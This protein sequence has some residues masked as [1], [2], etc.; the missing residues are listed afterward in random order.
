LQ[1]AAV[2]GRTFY[3]RVLQSIYE[4]SDL[5]DLS[6]RELLHVEMIFEVARL[7]ELEYIFRHSLTRETAYRTILRQQRREYHLKVGEALEELF[8]DQIERYAPTLAYHFEQAGD[9]RRAFKYHLQAGESA[10]RLYAIPQAL[11]RFYHARDILRGRDCQTDVAAPETIAHLYRRLGRALE[12]DS[13]FANALANYQ[14]LENL[15]RE[16]ELEQEL[17]DALISQALL[18]CT[19]TAMFDQ[20]S[21]EALLELSMTLAQELGDQPSQAKILWLELNLRRLVGDHVGAINAGERSLEIVRKLDLKEQL[22]YTL[23]DLG[24]AYS[25]VGMNTQASES[26]LEAHDLWRE[27]KNKPMLADNIA[28]MIFIHYV[29]GDYE[30]AIAASEEAYQ[31]SSSIHNLWGQSFSL[32]EV[33]LVYRDRG[34]YA[35]AL[36]IM[37][38]SIDLGENG[39][40]P[41]PRKY[42]SPQIGLV[43]GDLGLCD[44]GVEISKRTIN[45]IGTPL[46]ELKQLAA[47]AIIH[48]HLQCGEVHRGEKIAESWELPDDIFAYLGFSV[49]FVAIYVR[50]LLASGDL[51]GAM[52]LS[53]KLVDILI[54]SGY[55]GFLPEV[56]YYKG[57]VHLEL[58]DED[59]AYRVLLDAMER[60]E[61]IGHRRM[62]WQI[63]AAL[64]GLSLPEEAARLRTQALDILTF[65]T[66]HTPEGELRRSFLAQP[67]V[68]S[69]IEDTE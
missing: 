42:V 10:M 4:S 64:A 43:Y 5:L 1:L 60:A 2:I 11:E 49:L 37:Q 27:Y 25:G 16:C 33:G 30:A 67:A 58:G 36:E 55:V 45:E 29:E 24:Y 17:L 46:S 63:Q 8:S 28:G 50:L 69:L 54:R 62:L 40:S 56:L 38:E 44:Q 48:N 12:L 34:E 59:M 20:E 23:H 35:R 6:L 68:G 22:P 15:A 52:T 57:L 13:Q 65:I 26:F 32:M 51:Q 53:Q 61:S 7:P 18:R 66:D 14:E 41:V 21:G 31:I 39:N 47:L 19:A 3:Y 9:D